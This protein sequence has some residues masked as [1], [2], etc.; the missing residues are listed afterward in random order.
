MKTKGYRIQ[1]FILGFALAISLASLIAVRDVLADYNKSVSATCQVWLYDTTCK[2]SCQPS[3][4]NGCGTARWSYL[5]AMKVQKI[6]ANGKY[7]GG[8]S[9]PIYSCSASVNCASTCQ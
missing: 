1:L 8:Y 7:I 3:D 9:P 5:C 2:Y 4:P 6:Y